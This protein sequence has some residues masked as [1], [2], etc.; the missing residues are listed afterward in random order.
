MLKE[1]KGLSKIIILKGL[2]LVSLI[3]PLSTNAEEYGTILI[4]HKFDEP[5]TPSTSIPLKDFEA[6]MQYL[7]ENNFN[8]V[9]LS[10]FIEYYKKG[11]FPPK[12]VSITID[13]GYKSTMKAFK[14]LKKYNFPFTVFLY[15]EA[16]GRYPDFLTKKQLEEL[17]SYKK[18]EFGNHSYSHGR[19]AVVK[20]IKQFEKKFKEDTIKA[21]KRFIKLLGF[22][23]K[24]YAYPYG[25]YNNITVKI[26]KDLGYK[27]SFTQDPS[28]AGVYS[29]LFAIQRQPIVGHWGSL[30]HFK[31]IL[32]Y[33]QLPVVWHKPKF[34]LVNT[35]KIY[36]SAKI[37]NAKNYISCG[38]YI[39]E[40]GWMKLTKDGNVLLLKE[41]MKLKRKKNRIGFSCYNKKTKKW[42]TYFY[43][44]VK[45]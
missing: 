13:D 22:K 1:L 27:A 37:K 40:K 21:E 2:I 36:I 6:Q 12:T 39:S 10:K 45:E 42:A 25:D 33:E 19:F 32:S 44:I 29:N 11:Y 41:E 43:M 9:S 3:L 7:K 30:K 15:M 38:V 16:V 18:V 24:F 34:G 5:K 17:K 4:Y 35:D 28:S 26:L 20:D 23:P 8:V 14:V 31:K